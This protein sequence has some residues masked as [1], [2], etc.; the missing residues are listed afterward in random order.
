M[1]FLELLTIIFVVLKSTDVIDWSWLLVFSPLLLALTIYCLMFIFYVF[2]L[3]IM[4]EH[5]AQKELDQ[6]E[7][8]KIAREIER[9][10]KRY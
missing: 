8:E 2:I 9:K 10:N 4:A 6:M 1:G 3:P 5:Y 7:G